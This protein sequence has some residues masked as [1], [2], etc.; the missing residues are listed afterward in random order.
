VF[1]GF[2]WWFEFFGEVFGE[3][4]VW[5]CGVDYDLCVGW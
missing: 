4:F 3:E 5:D 1:G 2:W